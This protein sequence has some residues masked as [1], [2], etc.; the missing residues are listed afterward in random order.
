MKR[1]HNTPKTIKQKKYLICIMGL[2]FAYILTRWNV[3]LGIG[4]GG[5]NEVH[6]V[7]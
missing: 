6:V 5:R 4:T 2:C 7:I 1:F 3:N